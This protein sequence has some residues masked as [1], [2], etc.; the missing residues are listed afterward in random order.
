[1]DTAI[2]RAQRQVHLSRIS[3]FCP[4]RCPTQAERDPV[5]LALEQFYLSLR[6]LRAV[7][8]IDT[9]AWSCKQVICESSFPGVVCRQA[10]DRMIR[11]IE[12][13]FQIII[14]QSDTIRSFAPRDP[15]D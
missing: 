7:C 5:W 9:N 12:D 10:H 4:L 13:H 2:G 6:A 14:C 3:E 1:M 11:A 8:V 15:M